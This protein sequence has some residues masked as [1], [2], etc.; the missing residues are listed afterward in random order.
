MKESSKS[1]TYWGSLEKNVIQGDG[2]DI[3]C[4]PDPVTPR[5]RRFDLEDGDAN[6]ISHFVKDQFDFVYASHCLE[7]M[8]DPRQT[9]LDW[10]KLVKVGGHLFIVVPDEDL[11]EQGVFPSRF[12]NDHKATFTISKARSWSKKSINVLNL[13]KSLPFGEIVSL[14]LQD[15]GYDRS[16]ISF[17]NYKPSALLRFIAK[18]QPLLKKVM[19]PDILVG[20]A[21]LLTTYFP[22][23]QTSSSK[24][25]QAQIQLIVKKL[26]YEN[27]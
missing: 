14:E 16:M 27:Q 8:H 6:V 3:G 23:D 10:W 18:I 26:Q 9:I 15:Y 2:I 25:A 17:G 1:K 22:H 19:S 4:G 12:N 13:A 7:H 21:R 11:Y 24:N 20:V 5:A